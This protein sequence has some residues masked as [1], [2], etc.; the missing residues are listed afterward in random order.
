MI[1]TIGRTEMKD[2][3]RFRVRAYI[4]G[5]SFGDTALVKR[6]E[7]ADS[8]DQLR[9]PSIA[10]LEL[11]EGPREEVHVVPIT[12]EKVLKGIATAQRLIL[13]LDE[14]SLTNN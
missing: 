12:G 10:Y 11:G 4:D 1:T 8:K 9:V 13:T 6:S 2:Y 3:E 7:L 14:I 5:P